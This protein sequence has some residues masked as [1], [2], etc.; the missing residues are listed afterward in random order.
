MNPIMVKGSQVKSLSFFRS[1]CHP[2]FL[3]FVFVVVVVDAVAVV[4]VAV[5]NKEMP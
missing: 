4:V 3:L 1:T 5:V 2:F